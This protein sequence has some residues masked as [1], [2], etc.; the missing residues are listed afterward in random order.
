MPPN[1]NRALLEAQTASYFASLTP[2]MQDEENVLGAN[3]S[4]ATRGVDFEKEFEGSEP[5]GELES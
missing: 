1:D 5:R 4:A 2:E 3:L